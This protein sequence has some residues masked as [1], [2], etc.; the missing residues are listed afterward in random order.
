MNKWE[1]KEI[2]IQDREWMNQKFLDC[3]MKGCE[4]SFANTFIWRNIYK[5]EAAKVGECVLIRNKK[6]KIYTFP[7]GKE[8]QK[9]VIEEMINQAK[10]EGTSLKIRGIL[11]EQKDKMQEWFPE[12]FQFTAFRED[13]DYIYLTERLMTLAGKKLHG[14][15]NHIARFKDADDWS[16]EKMTKEN[17]KECLEMNDKWCKIQQCEIY[18]SL[19]QEQCAVQEA[20]RYFEELKLTGG[21]LRKAGEVVA[22]TIGEPLT[23]DTYVVH[24]EKAFASIQGAYP[25]IN[26]QFVL[27]NCKDYQYVNREEDMGEEGL[28]KAKSSYYPDILLEKYIA[29]FTKK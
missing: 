23:E 20:F 11:E 9:E 21:L 5:V 16:Y 10:K 12:Q 22:Y 18:H 3:K 7:I 13:A 27:A 4:Y 17:R 28:R 26:Q 6:S 14:K 1:F 25:M 29:E 24:I 15:R 8:G 19:Q 2:T